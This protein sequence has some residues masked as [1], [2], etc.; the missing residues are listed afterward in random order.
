MAEVRH[1]RVSG[2]IVRSAGQLLLVAN[3]RRNN[4]VDWSPPGGVIDP[5]ETP[6]DALTREVNEETG[7]AVSRWSPVRYEVEVD[8]V[9][10]AMVLWV[11][12]FEA[13][14]WDGEIKSGDDPDG[15]VIDAAFVPEPSVA[16]SLDGAPPWVREPLLS[17]LDDPGESTGG[18]SRVFRYDVI[19]RTPDE[20]DVRAR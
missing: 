20:I 19:G 17:W 1:W 14:A 10:M 13:H 12:V 8:F 7:L 9:D 15:I 3:R 5:G 2:G 4:E 18:S 11:G 6:I 16:E